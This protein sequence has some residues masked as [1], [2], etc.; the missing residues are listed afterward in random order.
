MSGFPA[1]SP[2][3]AFRTVVLDVA[4]AYRSEA[5][6]DAVGDFILHLLERGYQIFLCSTT[7]AEQFRAET[8]AQPGL[9]F[10]TDALPPSQDL[11][12]REPA[13][14]ASDTL[15]VTDDGALKEWARNTGLAHVFP[16][17]KSASFAP[18]LPVGSLQ[19]L[20]ALLD[21]TAATLREAAH[22]IAQAR[23]KRPK[24]ALLVGVGGPPGSDFQRFAVA[25]QRELEAGLAP[26][27]QLIDLAS[28][29]V[30]TGDMTQTSSDAPWRDPRTRDWFMEA[31][32][33]RL[34]AEERVYF[35]RLPLQAPRDFEPH[36]PLFIAEETIVLLLG[37]MPFVPPLRDKLDALVLLEVSPRESARRLFE[38]PEGETVDP[39][40]TAQYLAA[41]GKHYKTYLET[42]HVREAA[43][44]RI[45]AN[46][47]HAFFLSPP[48]RLSS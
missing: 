40:F 11:L 17:E 44:V 12:S 34:L 4:P 24:G 42:H 22:L 21:P 2:V 39:K 9:R 20:A 29:M 5:D 1:V 23:E 3:A 48:L 31:V 14:I 45:D 6:Q 46:R 13:L 33:S 47:P 19:E 7:A 36:I 41:E 37:E 26:L 15:W 38:L 28:L 43:T 35:E 32:I 25:L 18:G 16:G 10:L 8:Y 27:V 30:T